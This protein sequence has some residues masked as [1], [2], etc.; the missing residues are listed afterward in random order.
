MKL[1]P[2]LFASL[3]GLATACS[4]SNDTK[5]SEQQENVIENETPELKKEKAAWLSFY[6]LDASVFEVD[7]IELMAPTTTA[8][9]LYPESKELF[10][11]T[12]IYSPDSSN[13]I[14][15]YSYGLEIVEGE[16]GELEYLGSEVDTKVFLVN[17]DQEET[18]ALEIMM[19]GSGCNPESALWINDNEVRI[20]G[21][22]FNEDT[23]K[24]Y[25]TSWLYN[26]KDKTFTQHVAKDPVNEENRSF[27][28]DVIVPLIPGL[29]IE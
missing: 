15:M 27:F 12:F 14:D 22:T 3:I 18:T 7:G 5:S 1:T 21:T 25:P 20:L 6:D 26:L 29:S 9:G 11:G 10:S 19:C 16:N 28:N 4:E 24:N 8:Y 17:K 2:L 23:E 13:Y